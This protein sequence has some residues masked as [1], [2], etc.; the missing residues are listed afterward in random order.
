MALPYDAILLANRS[1]GRVKAGALEDGQSRI[2]RK[3]AIDFR[4][5][6]QVEDR[7][8]RGRDSSRVDAAFAEPDLPRFTFDRWCIVGRVHPGVCCSMFAMN[9]VHTG[10][11]SHTVRIG[12]K[13]LSAAQPSQRTRYKPTNAV[14][15]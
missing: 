11:G 12:S 5:S 9:C 14:T 2:P 4:Q 6:A 15:R 10:F 3:T 8:A 13:A 1:L 7:S